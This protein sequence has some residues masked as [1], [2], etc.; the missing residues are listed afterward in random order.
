M[1]ALKEEDD[2]GGEGIN[3]NQP[4][5]ILVFDSS[6]ARRWII[7]LVVLEKDPEHRRLNKNRWPGCDVIYYS[8]HHAG[9]HG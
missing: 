4:Q 6:Q 1:C 8:G 2:V 7:Y 9:D 5:S 3:L